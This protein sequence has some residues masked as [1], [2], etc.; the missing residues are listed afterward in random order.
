MTPRQLFNWAHLNLTN[1]NVILVPEEQYREEEK[2]LLERFSTDSPINGTQ[3]L[4]I[5]LPARKKFL[6]TKKFSASSESTE[7][8][9]MSDSKDSTQL[10]DY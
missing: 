5:S 8:S 6:L 1:V 9:V 2:L 7:Y 4:H 10:K 3:K